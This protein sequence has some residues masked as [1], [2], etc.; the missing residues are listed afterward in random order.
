MLAD[1]DLT[2]H[3]G[4]LRAT[5]ELSELCYIEKGKYVLDVGCGVGMTPCYL[6]EKYGCRVVGIDNYNRMIY[7]ANER[8]K[9]M[10]VED[11]VKFKVANVQN[12]P[13][14]DD[15]FDIV[16]GESIITTIE[17]K[18]RALSECVRVTK[19]GGYVGLNET[20]LMKPS[21]PKE[22]DEYLS[23][24]WGS[25]LE[26]LTSDDWQEL[27][28]ESG[29]RDI[30]VRTHKITFRSEFIDRIR[31]YSLKHFLRVWYR[32]LSLYIARSAY[33]TFLKEALSQ[34]K[35]LIEYW[36]YGIYVGRK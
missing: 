30:V 33:R 5:E 36:G 34:P 19:S 26:I 13:F 32:F 8:A 29:L 1:L 3:L 4:G 11:R 20:I 24:T 14:K 7:R 6:A 28:E 15:L 22:L 17:N 9:S 27:L 23:R 31:R 10:G 12:L 18:Q 2:K 21:P 16:I 35:E 25:N